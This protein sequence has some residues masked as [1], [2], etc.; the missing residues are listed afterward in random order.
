[1]ATNRPQADHSGWR[2]NMKHFWQGKTTEISSLDKK[3][4]LLMPA[5]GFKPGT[6]CQCGGIYT[7]VNPL[8]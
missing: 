6:S 2:I 7:E 3:P 4:T 1:M 5:V 8:P